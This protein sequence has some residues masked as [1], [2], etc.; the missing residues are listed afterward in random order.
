MDR[1]TLI[2]RWKRRDVSWSQI[3]SWYYSKSTWANSY[4]FRHPFTPNAKMLFGNYVGDTL[5][6]GKEKSLIPELEPHLYGTK[7]YE[8]RATMNGLHLVGY[9]DHYCPS[10]L[11]LNENKTSVNE[12]RWN[13]KLVDDHGQLTMYALMLLLS[14]KVVPEDVTMW[15]NFIPAVEGRYGV[16]KLP[17]PPQFTRFETKRTTKEVLLF[18]KHI[19]KTLEDMEDYANNVKLT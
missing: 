5:G 13:Q 18:G 14:E 4:L 6:L 19:R 1:K 2:L 15:L 9:C 16:I 8:L 12:E 7:E 17:D 11:I 3:S 10:K